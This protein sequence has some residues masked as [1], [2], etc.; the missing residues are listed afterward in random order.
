M[1]GM[2]VGL[3]R[4]SCPPPFVALWLPLY[5]VSL[6]RRA[7]A[8]IKGGAAAQYRDLSFDLFRCSLDAIV[9]NP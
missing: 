2:V 9:F 3:H 1:F 7:R 8:T 6:E 4:G 5:Q